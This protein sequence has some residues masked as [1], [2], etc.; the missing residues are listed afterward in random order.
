MGETAWVPSFATATVTEV[1]QERPG[2]VRIAVD[3]HGGEV[4]RAYAVTGLV[5]PVGVGDEV[6]LNTTAVELGLGTG[7]W[8]VVHWNLSR[9]ALVQPGPG[10]IMKLRYT[11]LQADTGAA[12]ELRADVL[13]DA[14]DLGGMPVVVGGLHSQ[15]PCVAVALASASPGLRVAYVMTDGGALPLALSELVPAMARAGLL[16]GTVTAGQ[17]FGGDHEAVNVPSALVVARHVLRAD[18]TIVAMGPG[19]VGTG[20]AL[21]FSALEVG[22]ALDAAERL[23]GRPVAV[24]RFS[25]GDERPR[26][27]GVSHHTRTALDVATRATATIG[28]P[29]GP[30]AS[31]VRDDLSAAGLSARHDLVDVDD[32][33]IPE[34]LAASGLTVTTM[35]R[36][37][38]RDPGAFAVAGAAGTV[39]GTL[40]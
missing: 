27:Q 31:R 5:G 25:L 6:V 8:H 18:V 33:G 40:L 13:A 29:R 12:E 3:V 36:G 4:H 28:V 26:H 21:G 2:L 24:C 15:V 32:P 38:D 30:F 9:G 20:T 37:P 10:H 17:A 22:P 11:S 35:G 34:L 39:A 1:L 23:G 14:A 19:G 16:V 7:G